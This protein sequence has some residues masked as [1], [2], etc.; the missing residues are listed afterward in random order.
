MDIKKRKAGGKKHMNYEQLIEELR[1]EMLQL[2]NTKCDALLQMYRSGEVHTNVKDTIRESN[3]ITV[4]PAELKGKRPLMWVAELYKSMVFSP[5]SVVMGRRP[6]CGSVLFLGQLA[7][8]LLHPVGQGGQLLQGGILHAGL[9]HVVGE[10]G[11]PSGDADDLGGDAH[12][13][14][15]V[16]HLAEDHGVGGDTGIIPHFK[17]T[18]YLGSAADEHV[19]ADGWVALALVLARAAQGHAVVDQ[20]VIPH[21]G[22]LADDDAHAVVDDQAASDLGPG[23]DLDARPEAAPL[24]HAPGQKPPVLTVEPVGHPVIQHRVDA[25]VQQQNFQLGPGGRVPALIGLQRLVERF[26]HLRF[27]SFSGHAEKTK[28]PYAHTGIRGD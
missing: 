15:V 13:G 26:K 11:G 2:V 27:L 7:L 23:V 18:Q 17:G 28:T 22:G 12:G 6:C 10:V 16:G 1:E 8:Q 3:L 24:G 21:L 14:G 4:S 20:A 5:S 25:L 9:V 19:V